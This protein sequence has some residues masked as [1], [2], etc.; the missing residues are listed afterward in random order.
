MPI[1]AHARSTRNRLKI[2]CLL[3]VLAV[4]AGTTVERRAQAARAE[5]NGHRTEDNRKGEIRLSGG[6]IRQLVLIS[7]AGRRFPFDSPGSSI[8]LPEGD[9][10]WHEVTVDGGKAGRFRA[11]G[12]QRWLRIAADR[13]VTLKLGGPLRP[14]LQVAS[15]GGALVLSHALRGE[16]GEAY[17]A[18]EPGV[19][20]RFTVTQ[21]GRQIASGRFAYG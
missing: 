4:G 15:R 13:P 2:A 14:S 20:P 8:V 12:P 5:P 6:S 10:R 3:G 1:H 16:G 18:C 9:Y 17:S 11:H 7:R 19:R 21:A